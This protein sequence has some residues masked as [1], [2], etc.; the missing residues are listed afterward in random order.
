VTVFALTTAKS[1]GVTTS[2]LA[3][4]SVWP[5][6][7][8][9]LAECDMA[10]GTVLA[11][12][13]QGQHAPEGLTAAA[14]RAL[15][16][17][18]TAE[19]L[20]ECT[21][22]IS[23]NGSVRLLPGMVDQAQARNVAAAATSLG[24][25]F[26]QLGLDPDPVDVLADCGRLSTSG[27]LTPVLAAADVVALVVRPQRPDLVTL[28][29]WAP[30]LREQLAAAQGPAP[31]V[32]ILI[33]GPRGYSRSEVQ[34]YFGQFGMP[35][36]GELAEDRAT[37]AFFAGEGAAPRGGLVRAP[38]P[39]S[40]AGVAAALV[41]VAEQRRRLLAG[42][43]RPAGAR[44]EPPP[45]PM[46]VPPAAPA[47]A[48]AAQTPA[49]QTPAAQPPAPAPPVGAP[50]LESSLTPAMTPASPSRRRGST[51]PPALSERGGT[52][53]AADGAVA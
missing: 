12:Y 38:L 46:P 15:R 48:P 8:L 35:V 9:L 26:T 20:L 1:P 42:T 18:L 30:R 53:D 25:A 52:A 27:F 23:D 4:A 14:R 36:W 11:G 29:E 40:A 21:V 39:R 32:G 17:G 37:A 5:G 44:P 10:G 41:G 7:R 13:R 6:G 31:A 43:S 45:P 34:S 50:G 22:D 3:L 19:Q 47:S 49:A 28:A 51:P 16:G 24:R 33:V 2:A